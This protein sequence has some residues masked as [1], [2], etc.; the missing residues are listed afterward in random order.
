[1]PA[2]FRVA[3]ARVG[4]LV[5]SLG[6]GGRGTGGAVNWLIGGGLTAGV[7]VAVVVVVP[8][9]DSTVVA[10]VVVRLVSLDTVFGEVP[11]AARVR[12]AASA[13]AA[14]RTAVEITR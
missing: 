9:V 13:Q 7:V 11:Q 6:S 14:I 8:V 10:S 1:M 5:V 4:A 12:P 3:G 2:G